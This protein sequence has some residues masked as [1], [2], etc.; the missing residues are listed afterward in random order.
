MCSK[1]NYTFLFCLKI[2]TDF[3]PAY[4]L[5]SQYITQTQV[6][7]RTFWI[8]VIISMEIK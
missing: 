4:L 6:S 2:K 5:Q 8:Y 1:Q 3:N 7:L